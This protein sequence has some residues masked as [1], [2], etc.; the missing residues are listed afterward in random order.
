M[1]KIQFFRKPGVRLTISTT[2]FV[3]FSLCLSRAKD[4]E[5]PSA[6][7]ARLYA[8]HDEHAQEKV[9]V[10][11]DPYDAGDKTKLFSTDFR[12]Y[13]FLPV[14]F[15]VTNDGDR[16]ISLVGM[17]AQLVTAKR[18]KL[19]PANYDDLMRRMSHPAPKLGPSPIPLPGG[20]VKGAVNRKT[21]EEIEQA[22]FGAR[23]VEP[24]STARGFLFFDVSDLASPVLAGAH[25]YLTGVRDA[26]GNELMYFEIQMEK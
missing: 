14:F 22:Q 4:F 24:H 16:P 12:A 18:A 1:P 9:T 21:R 11:I 26:S 20:K 13:G 3:L 7:A 10:A 5:M 8:A 25:F 19:S 6:Q 23:A 2:L 15:I 17:Q